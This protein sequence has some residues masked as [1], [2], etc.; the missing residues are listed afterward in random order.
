[1]NEKLKSLWLLVFRALLALVL[2]SVLTFLTYD[3][4]SPF[5]WLMVL[6]LVVGC[7]SGLIP[8]G[9]AIFE[10]YSKS[11]SARRER[12]VA[13]MKSPAFGW[14]QFLGLFV[15][16]RTRDLVLEPMHAEYVAYHQELLAVGRIR[17]AR[18]V[19]VWTYFVLVWAIG[20]NAISSLWNVVVGRIG[21]S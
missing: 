14:S 7:V 21:S 2:A 4:D 5:V 20:A 1:M 10:E 3:P 6:G 12:G 19:F 11:S 8:V 9:R 15:S 16:R 18:F 17:A 13:I